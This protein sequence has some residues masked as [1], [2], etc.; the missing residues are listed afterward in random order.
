METFQKVRGLK[1]PDLQLPH[2]FS[3]WTLHWEWAMLVEAS[4][5]LLC[6][7][8]FSL[9][10]RYKTH[11]FRAALFWGLKNKN[12]KTTT[13]GHQKHFEIS[14]L[15]VGKLHY[16][17]IIFQVKIYNS[18]KFKEYLIKLSSDRSL[19]II[20]DER[21]LY[22]FWHITWKSSENSVTLQKLNAFH[23]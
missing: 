1:L 7:L 11:S 13:P 2:G 20:F 8:S 12:K 16:C 22:S 17:K 3:I 9:Y 15:C 18:T 10:K 14:S 5:S 4:G 23:S 19:R 21:V 6:L